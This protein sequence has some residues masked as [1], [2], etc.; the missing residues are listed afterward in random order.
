MRAIDGSGNWSSLA[1]TDWPS[2]APERCSTRLLPISSLMSAPAEKARS[3]APVTRRARASLSAIESS[4]RFRSPRRAKLSALSASGRS[5]VI[6]ANSSMRRIWIAICSTLLGLGPAHRQRRDA[7]RFRPFNQLALQDLAARGQRIFRHRDEILRHV[8][9]RQPGLVQMRQ[10]FMCLRAGPLV[11]YD[12]QAHLLA[13]PLIGDRE[14]S[15]AGHGGMAHREV[16]DPGRVDVVAAA[17][18]QILFAADDFEATLIIEPS[19]IARHEPAAAVE[20]ILGRLLVVEIAEHQAGAAPADLADL[21]RRHFDVRVVLVPE[22]D[23]VG[24]AGAAA[25]SDDGF[26][27]VARQGV[28]VRAVLA[29]PVDVLRDDAAIQKGLRDLARDRRAGHVEG[30]DR[31]ADPAR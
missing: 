16:L 14:G 24:P 26:G 28:L 19:E 27:R 21:S 22:L 25:G 13:E 4:C 8:I 6:N 9:A 31:L 29:H 7:A 1:R 12:R 11:K 30:F 2:I 20:R 5:S 15:N 10:Q 18:D 23:L 17:D 3:P